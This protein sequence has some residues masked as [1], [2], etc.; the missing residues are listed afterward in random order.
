MPYPFL[1]T[2]NDFSPINDIIAVTP[3]D[4]TD[5]QYAG[6]SRPCRALILTGAGNLKFDTANGTTVTLP[7][8]S[9][10]FGVSYIRAKRIWSTGTTVTAGNIFAC[11]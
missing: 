11:Y 9:A 7:I 6:Q 2:T 3:S 8:S 1:D 5:L 10:W 4:S